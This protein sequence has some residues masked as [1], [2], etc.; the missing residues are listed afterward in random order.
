MKRL[1]VLLLMSIVLAS[2]LFA[3]ILGMGIISAEKEKA[4]TLGFSDGIKETPCLE[5]INK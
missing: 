4:Y 1:I 3:F 5:V 2:M